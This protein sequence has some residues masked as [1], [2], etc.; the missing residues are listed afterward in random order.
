MDDNLERAK[1]LLEEMEREAYERGWRDAIAALTKRA[2]EMKRPEPER[3]PIK[4]RRLTR[5]GRPPRTIGLVRDMI[6]RR[7]GLTGVE[8]VAELDET[9]TPVNE[10]TVRTN[11]RRLKLDGE[12]EQRDGRWYPAYTDG[13]EGEKETGETVRM[14]PQ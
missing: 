7:P 9:G 12:I 6:S 4:R 10:R 3:A 13:E 14:S 1:A 2:A 11:L 5:R 8:I